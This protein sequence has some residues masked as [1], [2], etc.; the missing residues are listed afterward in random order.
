MFGSQPITSSKNSFR[1][2]VLAV[3]FF[4]GIGNT[5]TTVVNLSGIADMRSFKL[6]G[7]KTLGSQSGIFN[8][9][10]FFQPNKSIK[11]VIAYGEEIIEVPDLLPDGILSHHYFTLSTPI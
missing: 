2:Q 7:D 10:Y 3:G 6:Y 9:C 4:I 11:K 1:V 8:C 5:R